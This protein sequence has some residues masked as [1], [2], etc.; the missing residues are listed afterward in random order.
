MATSATTKAAPKAAREA[1][2]A[3]QE[4]VAQRTRANMD[5]LTVFFSARRR[6]E[7]VDDRLTERV[8][9]LTVQADQRRAGQ[10]RECGVA[11]RA[12][13]DRG[14][15]VRDIAG[16]AGIREKT[17]RRAWRAGRHGWAA[18]PD[19]RPH[20][21]GQPSR[22]EHRSG[23]AADDAA[24]SD[25]AARNHLG[26]RVL[27]SGADGGPGRGRPLLA[28]GGRDKTVR[29]WDGDRAYT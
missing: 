26:H 6:A 25:V 16:M 19:V 29:V 22:H 14:E 24:V 12:M 5:D 2:I 27:R 18:L 1:T 4:A 7:A 8:A 23:I 15:S 17:A 20:P 28:S 13:K 3:A 10:L 9:A 21:Q 11:L